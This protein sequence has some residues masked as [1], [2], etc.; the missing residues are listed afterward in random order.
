MAA[1]DTFVVDEAE[2]EPLHDDGDTATTRLTF[3]AEHLEQRVMRFGPGRS[4]ERATDGRHELLYVVAGDG[5]LELTGERHALE[6]GTAAFVAPGE[7][8]AIDNTGDGELL[9]VAV[10]ATAD[11][12]VD[13]A[14][15]R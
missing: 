5:E 12:D 14:R 11:L 10:A 9:L 2:I 7:G 6:P 3:Q 13:A 4:R 15:R 8:Y 1:T